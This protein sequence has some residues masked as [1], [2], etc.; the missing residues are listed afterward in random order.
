MKTKVFLGI[1]AR[2]VILFTVAIFYTFIP[3]CLH[4]FFGDHWEKGMYGETYE[5]G[6]RHFW[7]A[8]GTEF[9]FILSLINLIMS[10]SKLVSKEYPE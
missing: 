3:E 7:F 9:L 4:N 2:I 10:C 1:A 5:W 6:I 8:V